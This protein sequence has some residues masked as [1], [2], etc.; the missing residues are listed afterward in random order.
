MAWS[1]GGSMININRDFI[2][3]EII[4]EYWRI[5]EFFWKIIN[6]IYIRLGKG[7]FFIDCGYCDR[8]KGKMI[9]LSQAHISDEK[10]CDPEGCHGHD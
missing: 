8:V 9:C 3:I 6:K 4:I 10:V 7:L 5:R 2:E 1:E